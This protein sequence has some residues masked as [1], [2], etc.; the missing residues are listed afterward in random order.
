MPVNVHNTDYVTMRTNNS[1][2]SNHQSKDL[3]ALWCLQ[4]HE[5]NSYSHLDAISNACNFYFYFFM[6]LFTYHHCAAQLWTQ[7]EQ[8]CLQA[9]VLIYLRLMHNEFVWLYCTLFWRHRN[10]MEFVCL[11]V[12]ITFSPFLD[13]GKEQRLVAASCVFPR[14]AMLSLPP[15]FLICVLLQVRVLSFM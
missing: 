6:Q 13:E 3:I 4:C 10:V 14:N 5:Q 12:A 11:Y 15:S 8:V 2:I 9:T 1:I 7:K